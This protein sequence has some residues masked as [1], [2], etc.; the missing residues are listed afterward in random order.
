MKVLIM[1]DSR[2]TGLEKDIEKDLKDRHLDYYHKMD[3]TV[4]VMRGADIDN[5]ISKMDKIFPLYTDYDMIY[6]MA[7]VNNQL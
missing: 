7:G 4:R 2:G 1:T 6:T 5:I 3:I